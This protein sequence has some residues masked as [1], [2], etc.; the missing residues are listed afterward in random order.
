MKH[1]LTSAARL[2]L[3]NT[4]GR[5]GSAVPNATPV[6]ALVELALAGLISPESNLT[7]RGVLIRR[8]VFEE[9]LP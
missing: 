7:V 9:M 4:T 6:A 5:A 3:V 8:Q 2:A 1:N